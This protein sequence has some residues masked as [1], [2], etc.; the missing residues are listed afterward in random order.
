MRKGTLEA[1]DRARHA[2]DRVLLD[3]GEEAE[4]VGN[5]LEALHMM[6][7]D[8]ESTPPDTALAAFRAV[9]QAGIDKVQSVQCHAL[10]AH[11]ILRA[12][13][14]GEVVKLIEADEA[15]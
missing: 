13:T 14:L 12:R 1:M 9:A 11:D 15:A 2:A 8:L 4:E 10:R 3:I 7:A 5:F 6:A